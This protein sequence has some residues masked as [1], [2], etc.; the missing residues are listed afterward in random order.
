MHENV[1]CLE[2]SGMGVNCQ[3]L[4]LDIE[5]IVTEWSGRR[6]KDHLV[7]PICYGWGC[8]SLDHMIDN[9]LKSNHILELTVD[10]ILQWEG[11]SASGKAVVDRRP[12]Q[13]MEGCE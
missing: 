10:N 6:L 8:L 11:I 13:P 4:Q 7:Q 2:M 1:A 5:N 3:H 9:I 12:L